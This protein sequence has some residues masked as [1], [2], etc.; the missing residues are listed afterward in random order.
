MAVGRT[1]AGKSTLSLALLR[2]LPTSGQVIFD[3]INTST[4][5]LDALRLNISIIPQSPDLLEGTL[6]ENL[7]PIGEHDDTVLSNALNA[8]GFAHLKAASDS[9]HAE[10]SLDTKIENGGSNFSQGQRQ[11]FALARAFVR[12]AK[13]L[14]MDEATSAIGILAVSAFSDMPLKTCLLQIIKRTA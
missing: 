9:N 8:A 14:I 12:K 13:L 10:I 2:T 1:G 11:M 7:D 5:N 6:R 3:G 4:L